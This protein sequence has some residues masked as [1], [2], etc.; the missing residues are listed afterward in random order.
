MANKAY[1]RSG[2][3][4]EVSS[5]GGF[6]KPSLID[7]WVNDAGET[8]CD[9]NDWSWLKHSLKIVAGPDEGYKTER[10]VIPVRFKQGSTFRLAVSP[11]EDIDAEKEYVI[12]DLD[13]YKA[14]KRDWDGSITDGDDVYEGVATKDS[15]QFFLWPIPE[16]TDFITVT[17]FLKWRKLEGDTDE[18]ITPDNSIDRLI[19]RLALSDALKK[20]DKYR[21][22]KSE[23]AE[24][25]EELEGLWLED[26]ENPPL[27]NTGKMKTT[28][29]SNY[30]YPNDSGYRD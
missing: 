11:A 19:I 20:L 3:Q 18:A 10:H 7:R 24:A 8:V 22:A 14:I 13:Q 9:Y 26:Q 30:N 27:G 28:R 15:G 4:A 12:K 21:Q 1:Y 25:L 29:E 23:R 6:V 16:K 5:R 2:V 17:G